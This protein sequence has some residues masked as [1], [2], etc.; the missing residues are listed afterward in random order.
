MSNPLLQIQL[1]IPFD[2]I[3]AEDVEPAIRELLED[4]RA[5]QSAIAESTGPR[6]FDNTLL[7]LHMELNEQLIVEH[8][9]ACLA[10]SDVD[11][12][13]FSHPKLS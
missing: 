12:N 5:A 9:D 1:K 2:R 6:T 3:R 13:F 4:A 8:R 11:N 10:V 7:A